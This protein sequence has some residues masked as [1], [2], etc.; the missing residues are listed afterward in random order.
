MTDDDFRAKVRARWDEVKD[1]MLTT[2]LDTI[3]YYKPLITTSADKNFEVWRTLAIP[4]G[5]QPEAMKDV[6]TFTEQV[7]Y[8]TKFLYS[9]KKWIDENL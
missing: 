3:N 2:A 6:T 7:Q 9:R 5:F 8:F 1:T 4:N